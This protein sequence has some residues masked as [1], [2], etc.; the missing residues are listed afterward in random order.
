MVLLPSGFKRF[1]I[2]TIL[3]QPWVTQMGGR[4]GSGE[5]VNI[6]ISITDFSFCLGLQC[7]ST[8]HGYWPAF[9][10]NVNT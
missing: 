9:I 6:R 5:Q 8:W 1:I 4:W 10:S 3:S 7:S 2:I